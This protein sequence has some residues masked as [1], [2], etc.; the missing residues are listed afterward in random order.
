MTTHNH[1]HPKTR[2][3]LLFQILVLSLLGAGCA[4]FQGGGGSASPSE[5]QLPTRIA[6]TIEAMEHGQVVSAPI[7][8][9]VYMPV[10]TPV[11]AEISAAPTRAPAASEPAPTALPSVAV[12]PDIP[13]VLSPTAAASLPEPTSA[14]TPAPT[15]TFKVPEAAIQIS[16]PGP[17]SKVVSPFRVSAFLMP[18]YQNNVTLELFGE[19]GRLLARKI[20]SYNRNPGMRVQAHVDFE[21]DISAAAETGRVV[22]RTE[23]EN[24]RSIA[25]ATVDLILLSLGQE[26]NNPPG[27][28][29]EKIAIIEPVKNLSIQA[30]VVYVS[31]LARPTSPSPL[32]IE[33]YS[34]K[35]V[36]LGPSRMV[37]VILEE[38]GQ[39][40]PF[41]IE[42]PYSITTPTK[43]RLFITEKDITRTKTVHVT[44]VEIHLRP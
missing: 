13:L 18:G 5:A 8:T 7:S 38:D 10:S 4:A 19:D 28:M 40:V 6:Q 34:E 35:G 3:I 41:S 25:M 1:C 23:D 15:P 20:L 2:G 26:E 9:S 11:S 17:S 14:E 22:V 39:H 21:F 33:L 24:Q 44:S 31:G 27:D 30:G 12:V 36:S 16:R 42:V 32:L 29:K 43:A 37:A